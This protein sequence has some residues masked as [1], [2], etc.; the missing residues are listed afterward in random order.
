MLDFFDRHYNYKNLVKR[1]TENA[2]SDR[3]RVLQILN[4]TQENIRKVPQ[5]FPIVDDHVWHI[6]V[7]GYG[8]DDQ[9]SDVFATLC[10]YVG[11][12]S[13]FVP[14]Y[15]K[16]RGDLVFLSFVRLDKEWRVF[17]PYNA[18]YVVTSNGE[19]ASIEDIRNGNYKIV[20]AG[21]IR[22]SLDYKMFF[23]NL[24]S[25]KEIGLCRSKVQS[26]IRRLLFEVKKWIRT[27]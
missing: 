1:I 7:R 14:V 19:L 13:F 25:I 17:D 4:W 12:E 15:T 5:D 9:A 6:I 3:E 21:E 27:K 18:V 23:E 11:L 26:P 2:R 16:N 20:N 10:N 22:K 24:P 8:T